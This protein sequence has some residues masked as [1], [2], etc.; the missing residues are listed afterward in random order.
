MLKI[1]FPDFGKKLL[2]SAGG[3]IPLSIVVLVQA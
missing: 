2:A 3:Q 1:A